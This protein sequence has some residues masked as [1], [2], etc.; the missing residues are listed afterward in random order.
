MELTATLVTIIV[1]TG[2]VSAGLSLLARLVYDGIKEKRNGSNGSNGPNNT[3]LSMDI[4][5][6]AKDIDF[7]DKKLAEIERGID[8][9]IE[10]TIATKE[11]SNIHLGDLKA[12][13]VDQTHTFRSLMSKL[14]TS[15]V[16]LE[17]KL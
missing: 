12:I 15:M 7:N 10:L 13:L 2:F 17:N 5:L 4:A 16:R 14:T 3:Q 1:I 6:L 9:L 8:K 11:Q